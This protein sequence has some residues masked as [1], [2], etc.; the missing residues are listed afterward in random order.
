VP[1]AAWAD[2]ILGARPGRSELAEAH[3]P[4]RA[5]PARPSPTPLAL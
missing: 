3:A 1:S 4:R 5:P 2:V